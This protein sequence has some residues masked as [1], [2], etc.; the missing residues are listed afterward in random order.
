MLFFGLLGT[1]TQAPPQG[2]SPGL[3]E[4]LLEGTAKGEMEAFAELYR[5]TDRAVYGFAL[6]ILKN[7]QDAQ[8]VM[9]ETY[10]NLQRAAGSYR[11]MGKP[12]AWVLTITRNLALGKLREA[13]RTIP[14]EVEEL[15]AASPP[16]EEG[17]ALE[18]K[19]VLEALLAHLG[20]EERQI[21]TLHA[22]TGLRHREIAAL[23]DIP[24][25]T[26]LSKYARALK[27]LQ[28]IVAGGANSP[29]EGGRQ[30]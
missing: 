3:L 19:L 16:V 30:L 27:K 2:T 8:D 21:L 9:Q 13:G 12:M 7:R 11:P 14:S 25:A 5:Q 4:S 24:L 1:L 17:Q 29:R 28:K 26:A 20:E 10:L 6:S 22:L 23:L 18:D 15:E